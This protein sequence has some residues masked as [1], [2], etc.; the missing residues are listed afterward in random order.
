MLSYKLPETVISL[1]QRHSLG[2]KHLTD[3]GPSDEELQVMLQVAMRAPDHGSLL[4]WRLAVV[5]GDARDRLAILYEQAAQ[6]AGKDAE[7]AAL[8][9]ERARRAPLTVALLARIDMGHPQVPAHEQWMAIG[10]ALTNFLNAVHALGYAGK[11]L[12]GNKARNSRVTQAFCLPGETLVGW[13]AVGT[14]TRTPHAR[15]PKADTSSVLSDW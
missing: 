4:P 8:D 3:P 5:R 2:I 14:P 10:G 15:S 1:L 9:A 13:V 6:D 12:S 7:A 11:M